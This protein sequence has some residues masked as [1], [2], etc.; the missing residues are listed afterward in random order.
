MLAS[1]N[2]TALRCAGP[3]PAWH[4]GA[5]G[6]E[7]NKKWSFLFVGRT[8]FQKGIYPHQARTRRLRY[9]LCKSRE[10]YCEAG[11]YCGHFRRPLSES[12]Q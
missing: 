1:A 5:R 12:R 9:L 7:A 3:L 2:C 11:W 10:R 6:S 8:A 4:W